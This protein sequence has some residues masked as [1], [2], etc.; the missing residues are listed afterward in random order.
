MRTTKS[1]SLSPPRAQAFRGPDALTMFG[2]VWALA[3]L[4]HL[5]SF[6]FWAR[7]WQGWL[8]VLTCSLVLLQPRSLP[9]FSIFIV[10]SLLNLFRAMPFVP[11]H[12]L[13]EGM[14]NLTII[15]S[16]SWTLLGSISLSGAWDFLREFI[17]R[18]AF[19][20]AMISAYLILMRLSEHENIC[21]VTTALMI[22][23]LQQVQFGVAP[24]SKASR[25]I[26]ESFAP[27]IRWEIV[28]MYFWAAVQKMNWDY[29]NP[30][31]SAA[32][33]LYRGIA[34]L[35]PLVPEGT[36]FIYCAIYGSLLC[37]AG[38]PI[39]LYFRSTRFAGVI[40]AI[41]FHMLLSIHPH[42]G[43]YS[44]SALIYGA[45][46]LFLS[47][48][49]MRRLQQLWLTQLKIV[50]RWSNGR[51][52]DTA[53]PYLVIQCFFGLVILF[54]ITYR[55]LGESK[56]TF[57]YLNRIGFFFWLI[58]AVW[59]GTAYIVTLLAVPKKSRSIQ[60]RLP[61]T[62]AL[63]GLILVMANGLNP[64]IGLK[65]QTSFSMFSNLRTEFAS[66]HLFLKRTPIFKYQDDM[67]EIIESN[68]NLLKPAEDPK[69]I[70]QFA[71][72]G[73]ILPYFE[74]RRLLARIE[75]DVRVVIKRNGRHELITR[76][77]GVVNTTEAFTTISLA[78][79][80]LLWFRRHEAWSGP[81]PCT[82]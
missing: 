44:Y 43:I 18:R 63:I 45:L 37:E 46:F 66:N 21:G 77:D 72:P 76:R 8:V 23:Y 34:D 42:P 68:P 13:F 81:M 80:K 26:F 11:N 62:P 4:M 28:V 29:L 20:I 82:H 47:P 16:I 73:R 48:E 2:I 57:L 52:S 24:A 35:I 27:I 50:Q 78:E 60:W 41:L 40:A 12:V 56:E 17:S 33:I 59:L 14:I 6:P 5:L 1:S 7:T 39:L 54:G 32:A 75:G 58:W 70:E 51:L 64:W 61:L 15:V 25:T 31:V 71:N 30:D 69:G 55:T 53:V 49:A 65:T 9:R 79:E 74:L 36:F 3:T 10:A 19:S 22:I 67:V 38:I